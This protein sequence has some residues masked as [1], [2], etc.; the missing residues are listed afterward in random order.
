MLLLLLLRAPS[1]LAK[2]RCQTGSQLRGSKFPEGGAKAPAN[3]SN[4]IDVLNRDELVILFDLK[5]VV[6]SEA[7]ARIK[8]R[9][10]TLPIFQ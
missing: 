8:D 9:R 2:M 3:F 5:R 10:I 1:V 7:A 6:A 4:I